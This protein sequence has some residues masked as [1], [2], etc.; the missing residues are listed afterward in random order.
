MQVEE[1]IALL[2]PGL[3]DGEFYF[4]DLT[5]D[6]N[7]FEAFVVSDAFEGKTRI[8]RELLVMQPLK[9]LFDGPL[10]ALSIKTYTFADWKRNQ[11]T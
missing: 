1:L 6:G 4:R 3:P 10:H 11:G 7:H 8:S 2:K 5:G 9:H